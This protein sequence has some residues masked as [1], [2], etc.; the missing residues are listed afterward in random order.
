LRGVPDGI[1]LEELA[2]AGV[3]EAVATL[4]PNVLELRQSGGR[5]SELEIRDRVI[6]LDSQ[7]DIRGNGRRNRIR[8]GERGGH[9]QQVKGR[10]RLKLL[11]MS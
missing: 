9:C 7:R 2:I 10:R 11:C 5:L 1:R 4:I 6:A 3:R 8:K